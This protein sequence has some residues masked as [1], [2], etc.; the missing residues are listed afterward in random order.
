MKVPISPHSCQHLLLYFFYDSHLN[1]VNWY[2]ITSLI[3]ISLMIDNV[4]HP[5]YVLLA[6]YISSL[7]KKDILKPL[8]C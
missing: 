2:L 4:E 7:E 8:T 3:Y 6:I 5:F 1:G